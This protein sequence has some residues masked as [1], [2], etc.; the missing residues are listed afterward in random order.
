[1]NPSL[2]ELRQTPWAVRPEILGPL[3]ALLA[4]PPRE[5]QAAEPTE[6]VP[7]TGGVAVLRLYGVLTARES[8]LSMLFGGSSLEHFRSNFRA[9][10]ASSD[11]GSLL[12]DI[13]SPGGSVAQITELAAEIRAARESKPIVAVANGMAASGA[14]WLASQANE[15]VITPSGMAGS[16]GVYV[17]HEDWSGFNEK[18]GIDPTYVS[19]GKYK[20]EGNMDSPLDDKARAAIQ[21]EVDDYYEMFVADV[22]A[23]RGVPEESVR[24]GY[25][26]GRVLTAK[27][28]QA[29]GMVDRIASFDETVRRLATGAAPQRTAATLIGATAPTRTQHEDKPERKAP[30]AED[31]RARIA[32]LLAARPNHHQSKEKVR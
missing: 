13:D 18:A 24:S 14:Y 9:A 30:A 15:V 19:A 4:H 7:T 28:A 21:S 31:D 11:V 6:D 22:A 8:F 1:M 16:I 27:R 29:E 25:G 2:V 32:R 23:G 5:I 3:A 17:V 12:L 20:V 26:E 10:L